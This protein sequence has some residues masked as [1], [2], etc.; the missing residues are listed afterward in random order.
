M[1][2]PNFG[3]SKC[4]KAKRLKDN[5]CWV[6]LLA[7]LTRRSWILNIKIYALERPSGGTHLW[8]SC[9]WARFHNQ[10]KMC[11][12]RY[13]T[14]NLEINKWPSIEPSFFITGLDSNVSEAEFW[15]GGSHCCRR[16]LIL[17]RKMKRLRP[18]PVRRL[19]N[20]PTCSTE[21]ERVGKVAF[22]L[23]KTPPPPQNGICSKIQS[24]RY[25]PE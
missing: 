12:F 7:C 13:L 2:A 22:K 1:S 18:L 6:L 8:Q 16:S 4:Q 10:V 9:L 5:N 14:Y 24:C 20:P 25:L 21:M 17:V 19:H 15:V 23:I 11:T 3:V